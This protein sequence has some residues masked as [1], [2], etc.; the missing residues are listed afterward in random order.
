MQCI[1]L[2]T[3]VAYID[4]FTS[5]RMFTAHPC[6][7]RDGERHGE[8]ERARDRK[9]EREREKERERKRQKERERGCVCE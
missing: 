8:R 3:H 6:G 4:G 7:K 9:R 5:D 1:A 2:A